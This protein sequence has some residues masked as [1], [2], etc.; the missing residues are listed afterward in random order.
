MCCYKLPC[1]W[2][3]ESVCAGDW[4]RQMSDLSDP[5]PLQD[6]L[7]DQGHLEGALSPC[8]GLTQLADQWHMITSHDR[9]CAACGVLTLFNTTYFFPVI[10]FFILVLKYMPPI[11]SEKNNSIILL[12]K[13]TKLLARQKDFPI[14]LQSSSNIS[15]IYYSPKFPL[16]WSA[17]ENLPKT[18]A[19]G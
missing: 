11:H 13:I 2:V 17:F 14:H 15:Q 4:E 6:H 3:C 10:H 8:K 16:V 7:L 12:K 1:E 9:K 19:Q 5:P 18:F